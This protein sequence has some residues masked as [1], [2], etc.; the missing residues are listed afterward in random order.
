MSLFC[1][2]GTRQQKTESTEMS[3]QIYDAVLNSTQILG[4]LSLILSF[5]E[6]AGKNLKLSRVWDAGHSTS[7]LFKKLSNT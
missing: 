6:R 1:M 3:M 5:S 7:D 2:P 4:S